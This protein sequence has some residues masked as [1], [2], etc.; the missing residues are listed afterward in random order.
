LQIS[1]TNDALVDAPVNAIRIRGAYQARPDASGAPGEAGI[2]S[3]VTDEPAR[4]RLAYERVAVVK[5]Q[6][7]HQINFTKIQFA[8]LSSQGDAVYSRFAFW[9]DLAFTAPGNPAALTG[10]DLF[11][12]DSLQIAN[13]GLIMASHV[14]PQPG[15]PSWSLDVASLAFDL[16]TSGLRAGLAYDLPVKL[17]RLAYDP[18]GSLTPASFGCTPLVLPAESLPQ[19][20]TASFVLV[21]QID[22]G[23]PGAFAPS[24]R[25]L[26]ATLITGWQPDGTYFA[27]LGIPGLGP[28]NQ[29]PL[30][31]IMPLSVASF[32]LSMVPPGATK[33]QIA[34]QFT[35]CTVSFLGTAIPP[36]PGVFDISLFGKPPY[37]PSS[38]LWFSSV[39][40][41][42]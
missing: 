38:I 37:P 36:M 32:G 5:A 1:G 42:S 19:G 20:D 13:L 11:D 16:S 27:A 12:F 6:I 22:L 4:F 26:I 30:Q 35:S 2:Y 33:Q 23:Q 39:D 8:P 28:Q 24:S 41:S 15:D 21:Y 10:P 18:N 29:L 25:S 17:Q 14:P 34:I 9:G 31:G 7:L 40:V 3:F